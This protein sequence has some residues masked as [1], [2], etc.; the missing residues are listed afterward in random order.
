MNELVNWIRGRSSATIAQVRTHERL[1][2]RD[3][4]SM[5]DDLRPFVHNSITE[6]EQNVSLTLKCDTVASQIHGFIS[7]STGG[8]RIE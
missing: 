2:P 1:M 7:T 3:L 6:Y 4:R 8:T 5:T